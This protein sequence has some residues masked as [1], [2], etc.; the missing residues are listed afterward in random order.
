MKLKVQNQTSK[1]EIEFEIV[2]YEGVPI[3]S[4]HEYIKFKC[5]MPID[6]NEIKT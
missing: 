1:F 3:I 5:T 4:Y 6:I 2:E